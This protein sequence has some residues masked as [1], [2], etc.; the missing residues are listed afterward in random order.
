MVLTLELKAC[1]E[2]RSHCFACIESKTARPSFGTSSR[3][4]SQ[5]LHRIHVDT[6][7]PITPAAMTGE[8]IL[9]DGSR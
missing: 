7:G 8:H 3:T 2:C 6:V 1:Q 9:G 5:V 4:A